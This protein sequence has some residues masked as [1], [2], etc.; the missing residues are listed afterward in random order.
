MV[1]VY[2]I[3]GNLESREGGLYAVRRIILV[4]ERMQH[5]FFGEKL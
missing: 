2:N 4:L 3:A 1:K 5:T